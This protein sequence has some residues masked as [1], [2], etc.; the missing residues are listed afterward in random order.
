MI[1]LGEE[2]RGF[3]L[4][5]HQYKADTQLYLRLPSDPMVVVEE[6]SPGLQRVEGLNEDKQA[7]PQHPG[8]RGAGGG[9]RFSFGYWLYSDAG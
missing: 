3:G 8:D 1:P 9:T 2:I 6:L 5:C 7:N 4:H